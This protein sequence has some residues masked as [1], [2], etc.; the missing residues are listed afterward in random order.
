MADNKADNKS[1][2]NAKK[3][4]AENQKVQEAAR[5][6][7]L[8]MP[9]DVKPTPTQEE[10]DLAKLGAHITEHEADGSPVQPHPFAAKQSEAGKPSG[11]GYTT[12]EARPA[13][14]PAST[15]SQPS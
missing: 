12:R 3:A 11:G 8:K 1:L 14:R 7:D 13:A 5:E 15:Q 9:D 2:E 6:K 10:N 4:L